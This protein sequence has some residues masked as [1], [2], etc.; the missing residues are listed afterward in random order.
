MA[1]PPPPAEPRPRPWQLA[2]TALTFYA[3]AQ[4][5]WLLVVPGTNVGVF[6][7]PAGLA[8]GLMLLWGPRTWPGLALGAF[9][10]LAP[11]QLRDHGL[12]LGG[13]VTLGE[14]AADVL[15]PLLATWWI[16]R[17]LAGADPLARTPDLLKVVLIG[18]VLAQALAAA[19]GLAVI[20]LSSDLPTTMLPSVA[21]NW[22]F[23]NLVSVSVLGTLVLAWRRPWGRLQP[24]RHLLIYATTAAAGVLAFVVLEPA[25][26]AYFRYATILVVILAAFQLGARGASVAS[27]ILC[28]LAVW[29][30]ASGREQVGLVSIDRQLLLLNFYLTTL[31]LTGLIVAAVLDERRR[32]ARA[33]AEREA[34]LEAVLD[35]SP[36][37]IAWAD[38]AGRIE[39]WSARA[40]QV[41]GW[42]WAELPT[43]ADWFRL[44]YPDPAY[45]EALWRQWQAKLEEARRTGGDI[46]FGE[47]DVAT[48]GGA[49]L[50]VELL[51]RFAGDR[52]VAVFS[53]LTAR[54]RAQAQRE[55]LRQQLAQAQRMESVGRLAGGVAHDF[56]NL[57]S[58]ILGLTD[59]LLEEAAPGSRQAGDLAEVKQAAERA[60]DLT[61]QLLAFGRKQVLTL[62]VLD[63]RQ[64]LVGFE[65]LLRR[66]IREDVRIELRLPEALGRVRADAG[67]VEQVVMNLAV[68][69]QQAMP[70]G[71]LLVI[72]AADASLREG[73]VRGVPAGRWVALT[74]S[75]TGSGMPPEVLER[76]FEPFFTT[77]PEGEGSGL[78]LSI[79]HGI[80]SQH[81]GHVVAES[82]PGRGTTFRIFLP[83]AEGAPEVGMPPPAGHAPV[84]PGT[85]ILVAE[86][87]EVV[88]HSVVRMLERVGCRVLAAGDAAGC[89]R[90]A[91]QAGGAIDL[92][93]TDVVMP[94][95]NGRQLHQELLRIQPGLRVLFMSG[96]AGEVVSQRGV[97][98]EGL[99]F[100]QKPFTL[101]ALEAAVRRALGP[102]PAAPAASPPA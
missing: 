86:D 2:V 8:L 4:V 73:E 88:R 38:G 3:G 100:I 15:P 75:D 59:L 50:K 10:A 68:N 72:E 69:A 97:L 16:R 71:G 47:I 89:R 41:F 87:E 37:P 9:A 39:F 65:R 30:E 84:R 102:R 1:A 54:R 91:A 62:Q 82:Q 49:V 22:W 85:T 24:V 58:P 20:W 78:G 96:Y 6:W 18:G 27:A 80:V 7:P 63:L 12:L 31:S 95:L 17:A 36:L 57:L 25:L 23:S 48:K 92:L 29:A 83:R 64:A 45:R 32:G 44:A 55:E 33:L 14:T 61:R 13:A 46:Q 90:L 93:V 19:M 76:V 98:E 43:L 40:Q 77:R 60:R 5:G 26:Q 34:L 52:L 101:E 74:V 56:N 11:E 51:S 81:G 35:A 94:D 99:E 21:V 67:H 66:T 79:V 28:G 53:D 42:T 70:Q